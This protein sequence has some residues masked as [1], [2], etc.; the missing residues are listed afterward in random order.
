MKMKMDSVMDYGFGLGFDALGDELLQTPEEREKYERGVRT[1]TMIR[2][3][4][5]AIDA[6]RERRGMTKNELAELVGANPQVIRRLFTSERANPT[7]KTVLEILAA[8]RI[9]IEFKVPA[10]AESAPMSE[11]A[12]KAEERPSTPAVKK[13]E[14]EAA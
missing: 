7:L 11:A 1:M 8:L 5:M 3:L 9:E 13:A 14:Q 2:Q 4:L 6:E 12:T 10:A